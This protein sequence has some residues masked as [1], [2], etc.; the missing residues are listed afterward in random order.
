MQAIYLYKYYILICNGDDYTCIHSTC[1]TIHKMYSYNIIC[2][3]FQIVYLTI[4]FELHKC[5]HIYAPLIFIYAL[6]KLSNNFD[7]I[8]FFFS[9][10]NIPLFLMY[11]RVFAMA[12][13]V[14]LDMQATF[15][16]GL[17]LCV[18]IKASA[19]IIRVA[20]CCAK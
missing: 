1:S 18:G 15:V 13:N 2:I 19:D 8:F 9:V 20:K 4:S 11:V 7:T 17:V 5:R 14:L 12:Y 3:Y 10:T 16:K 6:S